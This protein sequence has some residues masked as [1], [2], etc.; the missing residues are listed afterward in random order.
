MA[1][2]DEKRTEG[3]QGE[4]LLEKAPYRLAVVEAV[5]CMISLI[6]SC[7]CFCGS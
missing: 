7:C 3:L 1:D 5:C 2:K 4:Y 6:F